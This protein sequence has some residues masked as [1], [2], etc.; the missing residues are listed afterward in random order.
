VTGN[1]SLLQLS[2]D[3]YFMLKVN[4]YY[5]IFIKTEFQDHFYKGTWIKAKKQI[6]GEENKSAAFFFFFCN[7]SSKEDPQKYGLLG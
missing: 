7:W 5:Q 1:L 3:W 2:D 6:D 4:T